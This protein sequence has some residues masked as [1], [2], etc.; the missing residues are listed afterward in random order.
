MGVFDDEACEIVPHALQNARELR[1][2][3]LRQGRPAL[4]ESSAASPP[5]RPPTSPDPGQSVEAEM[6]LEVH[7]VQTGDVPEGLELPGPGTG[8]R[9]QPVLH[10]IEA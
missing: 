5:P 4:R 9:L 6:A 8:T 3:L 2:G 7:E 1:V 10:V